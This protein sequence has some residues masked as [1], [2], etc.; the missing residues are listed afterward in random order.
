VSETTA[1][2]TPPG[3]YGPAPSARRRTLARVG[4]AALG[5]V[6]VVGAVWIGVT[7]GSPAVRWDDIGYS[8]RGP[9]GVEVTFQVVKDPGATASCT[10][11]ALSASYA[12][13]G[14]L[15]TTV[16]PAPDRTVEQTVTVA[17]QERAVTGVVD[18]CEIVTP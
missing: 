4:T 14:V 12:Q 2:R 13:V 18:R 1:P 10:V 5:A 7:S 8:V 6:A 3:R 9:E 16:G 15:T 11:T 17:T